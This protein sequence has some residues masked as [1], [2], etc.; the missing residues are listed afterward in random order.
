MD[1]GLVVGL[2]VVVGLPAET[3]L[4]V[5]GLAVTGLLA[6]VGF[7][8]VVGFPAPAGLP[9]VAGLLLAGAA[10][11]ALTTAGASAKDAAAT[12]PSAVAESRIS[13]PPTQKAQ[14][15]CHP[16]SNELGR[17][18]QA[19]LGV[20]TDSVCFLQGLRMR[21]K[22]QSRAAAMV[23]VRSPARAP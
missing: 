11:D 18:P 9:A 13:M 22:W 10:P 6:V 4:P 7:T 16:C 23:P 20:L 8:V 5:T 3:G 19:R 2:T 21:L 1:F 15:Q 14:G 17:N 12:K